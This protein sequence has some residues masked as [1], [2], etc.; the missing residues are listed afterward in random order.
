MILF[1][2]AFA[3][4]CKYVY[5][6]MFSATTKTDFLI[7]QVLAIY[8][9]DPVYLLTSARMSFIMKICLMISISSLEK[10]RI[11]N[12]DYIYNCN[13]IIFSIMILS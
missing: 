11:N 7:A 13:E 12:V 4:S 6:T 10:R 1:Y 9:A 2:F 5:L 3:I 8:K